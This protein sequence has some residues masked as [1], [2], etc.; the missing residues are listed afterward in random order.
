MVQLGRPTTC[1]VN[2]AEALT[3]NVQSPSNERPLLYWNEKVT[4][5]A[6]ASAAVIV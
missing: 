5:P 1:A 6:A 3:V 2:C 4:E